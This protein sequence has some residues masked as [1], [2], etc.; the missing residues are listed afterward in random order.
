MTRE[1]A[2]KKLDAGKELSSTLVLSGA[3]KPKPLLD[4]PR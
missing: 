2:F 1:Q 4:A 3:K